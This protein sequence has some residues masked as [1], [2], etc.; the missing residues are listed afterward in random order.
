MKVLEICMAEFMNAFGY[1]ITV[2][3]ITYSNRAVQQLGITS[4]CTPT[5]R[6]RRADAISSPTDWINHQTIIIA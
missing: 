6:G 2:L 4:C 3:Q 5:I 1:D